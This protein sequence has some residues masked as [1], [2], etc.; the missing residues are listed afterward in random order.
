MSSSP[1]LSVGKTCIKR[2]NPRTGY[3]QANRGIMHLNGGIA[4]PPAGSVGERE[5]ARWKDPLLLHPHPHLRHPRPEKKNGFH[6]RR[7]SHA[8]TVRVRQIRPLSLP[9]HRL[10]ADRTQRAPI[11]AKVLPT[12][13]LEKRWKTLSRRCNMAYRLFNRTAA[14]IVLMHCSTNSNSP[15]LRV[16]YRLEMLP[17]QL[18]LQHRH[19]L[20]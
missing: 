2:V 6:K 19:L 16:L 11:A 9:P 3:R 17:H 13:T 18:Q 7:A 15:T 14:L 12:L 20:L 4:V 10:P 5:G 1:T 8:R